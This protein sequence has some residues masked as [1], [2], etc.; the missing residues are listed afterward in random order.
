MRALKGRWQSLKEIHI[1]IMEQ[2]KHRYTLIWIQCCLILHNFVI[3]VEKDLGITDFAWLEELIQTGYN[4]ILDFEFN[5]DSETDS[6]G[7]E[8]GADAELQCA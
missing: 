6:D 7:E 4:D 2:D 3:H 1:Q 5:A 8:I